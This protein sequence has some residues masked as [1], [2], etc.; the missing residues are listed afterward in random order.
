MLF[1][2]TNSNVLFSFMN[3]I[4]FLTATQGPVFAPD[5]LFDN[6]RASKSVD[7][8]ILHGSETLVD[9]LWGEHKSENSLVGK[10]RTI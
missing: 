8:C 4:Y 5:R 10:L 3:R 1:Q 2:V 9:K 7:P 6:L